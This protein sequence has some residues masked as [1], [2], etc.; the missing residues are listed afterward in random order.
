MAADRRRTLAFG[1]T[2][3]LLVGGCG[4]ASLDI[5]TPVNL[6][7]WTTPTTVELDAP[8]WFADVS[9]VYLC[10]EEPPRLPDAAAD[11]VGW[12][13][14]VG[15]EFMGSYP[16]RQGLTLSMPL[17]DID[18]ARRPAFDAARDWYIV[19]LDLDGDRVGAAIRSQ[20]HAPTQPPAT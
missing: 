6:H 10:P 1:L 5:G 16:S 9:A 19:L 15:C 2:G 11:R 8:G 4:P 18:V 3:A 17:D 13:P 12:T 20:F 7:V 14:G